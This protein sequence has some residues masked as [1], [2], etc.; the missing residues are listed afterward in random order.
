MNASTGAYSTQ[1]PFENGHGTDKKF[2][3]GNL[4]IGFHSYRDFSE[5]HR[6]T[7]L[8]QDSLGIFL[9][10]LPFLRTPP[11]NKGVTRVLRVFSGYFEG[12]AEWPQLKNPLFKSFFEKPTGGLEPPTC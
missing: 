5:Q 8:E 6:N 11:Y 7:N 2:C 3:V 10:M 4:F 1:N 9:N 12:A